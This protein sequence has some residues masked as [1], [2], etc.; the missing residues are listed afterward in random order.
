[1]LQNLSIDP[2]F[3]SKIPPLTAEER[4]QLEA[5]I[6]EALKSA[7]RLEGHHRGWAQLV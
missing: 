6:L 3:Q 7:D 4:S 2:E 5:N 1:M